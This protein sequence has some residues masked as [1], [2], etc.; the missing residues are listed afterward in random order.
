V[1]YNELRWLQR[2]E[3]QLYTRE[4]LRAFAYVMCLPVILT[5]QE[6]YGR[7]KNEQQLIAISGF[8]CGFIV[9]IV[10]TLDI[11]GATSYIG[12]HDLHTYTGE[13]IRMLWLQTKEQ[14]E[15]FWGSIP[16]TCFC[17]GIG[18]TLHSVQ[19][20]RANSRGAGFVTG[21]IHAY[22][23]FAI[24]FFLTLCGLFGNAFHTVFN[25]T[26]LAVHMVLVP[27]WMIVLGLALMKA[28]S[29]DGLSAGLTGPGTG[30]GENIELGE[31]SFDA[32]SGGKA[33]SG[34]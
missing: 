6:H 32:E 4:M 19:T 23:G 1:L 14:K 27:A 22:I 34:E 10:K 21:P 31:A 26:P 20:L 12:R 16:V 28:E 3:W 30:G 18:F 7:S 29:L 25:L 13:G 15:S 17:L 24:G 11:L 33:G 5:I 8:G 2:S 9:R